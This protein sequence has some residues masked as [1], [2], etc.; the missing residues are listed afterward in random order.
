MST[1]LPAPR[2]WTGR[3]SLVLYAVALM[4]FM[5]ASSVPTPLYRLYQEAWG[6]SPAVLT[7]IFGVY[8]ISILLALLTVGSLSDHVGR[9]P[10]VL[11]ALLLEL[12]AMLLFVLADGPG[13]LIVARILQ[14][15]AT[16]AATS[17][18]SAGLVDADQERGP[19]INGVAPLLGLA[20]GTLGCSIL[21]DF[22]PMPLH[23]VFV[24]LIVLFV[25]Q[26]AAVIASPETTDTRHGA[27]ASLRPQV[28]VP[29][30]S[31]RNLLMAAPISIA[32]WGLGGFYLSLVPSIIRLVTGSTSALTGG[33][34]VTA[35]AVSG[36][37]SILVARPFPAPRIIAI[38]AV[39]LMLGV[40][41]TLAGI[42]TASVPI[43]LAGTMVAGIGFGSGFLGSLRTALGRAAADERAGLMS[44]LYIISYLAFSLPALLAGLLIPHAGL[45][46]TAHGY[47]LAIILLSGLAC[48]VA[49][50][51]EPKLA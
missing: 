5:A 3:R 19:F 43:M 21:V 30:H 1:A 18:L 47:G 8:A 40:S 51:L 32:G 16:G 34:V 13:W 23:L 17:A 44:A 31:R 9:R 29:R 4:T 27:I 7:L 25:L 39:M 26:L 2:R 14:G 45:V 10:V 11:G 46:A 15:F 12:V 41:A 28:S 33:V 42:A 24:V 38:A 48:L 22:G 35:L 36:A 50:R 37:L 20:A 6:F 49:T